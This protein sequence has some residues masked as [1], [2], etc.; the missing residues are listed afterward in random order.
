MNRIKTNFDIL[1]F[2]CALLFAEIISA[3]TP[4]PYLQLGLLNITD[5]NYRLNPLNL[6]NELPRERTL[7]VLFKFYF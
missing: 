1:V 7:S 3:Q 5:Q 6:Y 2:S 4:P